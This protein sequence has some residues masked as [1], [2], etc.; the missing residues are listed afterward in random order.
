MLL[1]DLSKQR[2]SLYEQGRELLRFPVSTALNGAGE[3][4]GSGCTPRGNHRIRIKIGAH[5]PEN[6]VF[7]ARRPSGEVFSPKLAGQ[8]P[9]RDWILTRIL[10]LTGIE[11]GRNR[12][13]QVDTLRRFIYIHGCP[14][15]EPMGIPCSHGCIRMR[16]RDLLQLF[17]RVKNGMLVEIR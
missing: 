1:I 4:Y 15:R 7:I 2:L 17:D 13:G 6:T 8:Q 10:W 14:D 9:E 16:N 11:P 12:G 3:Q 5:C